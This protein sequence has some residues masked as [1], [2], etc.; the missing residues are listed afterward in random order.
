MTP[1]CP[2]CGHPEGS[3]NASYGCQRTGCD[4][5]RF[6]TADRKRREQLFEYAK[7]DESKNEEMYILFTKDEMDEIYHQTELLRMASEQD[8]VRF[9]I[10]SF[11]E[12]N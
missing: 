3:H 6:T 2:D 1:P 8:F 5:Q 4:C 11:L 9:C 12:K 10:K 7:I